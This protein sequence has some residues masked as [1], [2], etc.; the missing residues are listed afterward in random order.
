M[1]P[2]SHWKPPTFQSP[3]H[4]RPHHHLCPTRT[5]HACHVGHQ[6][7]IPYN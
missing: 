2:S 4:S 1:N 3:H 7:N 6:H 5:Y